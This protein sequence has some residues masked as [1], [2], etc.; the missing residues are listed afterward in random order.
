[1]NKTIKSAMVVVMMVVSM[2]VA[3]ERTY[4]EQVWGEG[5][6]AMLE[7][8]G[9]TFSG[10]QNAQAIANGKALEMKL[11][12][13]QVKAKAGSKISCAKLLTKIAIDADTMVDR[14][15]YA[16]YCKEDK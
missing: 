13:D 12:M 6:V 11:A 8:I 15:T 9:A 7:V 16:M 2:S 1:M 3:G 10:A 14:L 5:E 4:A